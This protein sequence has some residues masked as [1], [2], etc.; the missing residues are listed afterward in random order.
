MQTNFIFQKIGRVSDPQMMLASSTT[1]SKHNSKGM[2]I[3]RTPFKKGIIWAVV[4]FVA[5]AMGTVNTAQAQATAVCELNGTQFV[6][7]GAALTALDATP[8]GSLSTIKLLANINHNAG[9]VIDGKVVTFDMNGKN[10]TVN[11]ND[12]NALW[13]QNGGQVHMAGSG[14]FD[15]KSDV[16]CVVVVGSG[17]K[18]TVTNASAD[19]IGGYV[20]DGG[21][22]TISNIAN[23]N[24]GYGVGAVS[25]GKITVETARGAMGAG[26]D[27]SGSII[28]V[29]NAIAFDSSGHGVYASAGGVINVSG[30]VTANF[31]SAIIGAKAI[32]GGQITIEGSLNV[33]GA[34]IDVDGVVKTQAQYEATTTKAGYLTYTGGTST[35]WVKGEP[36]AQPVSW[37][38]L[39]A[40]GTSGT[41]ATTALTL[42]FDRDPQG[43]TADHVDVT[44]ATKGALTGSGTTRTLAISNILVVNGGNITVALTDPDGIAI[45]PSSRDVAVFNPA[46]PAPFLTLDYTFLDCTPVGGT[47]DITVTSNTT[48]SVSSN[49]SWVTVPAGSKNGNGTF[50][51]TIA[52]NTSPTSR[53]AAVTVTGT[54]IATLIIPVTQ[55]PGVSGTIPVIT[56]PAGA[57]APG[58]VGTPYSLTLAATN[59]PTSWAVTTGS[60][61]AGLTLNNSGVISGTPT[62]ARIATFTVT[63]T[64]ASGTSAA[65]GFSIRINSTTTKTITV[66]AQ[67]NTITAGTGGSATFPATT[68][69]IANGNYGVSA[70]GANWPSDVTIGSPTVANNAF[71]ITLHVTATVSAGIYSLS[72]TIDGTTSNTFNLVVN[73]AATTPNLSVSPASLDF[74]SSAGSKS[75]TVISNV[76]NWSV[77]SNQSWATVT[78]ASGSNNGTIT[79]H[80]AANTSASQRTATI[81]VSGTGVT[82]QTVT[83]TQDAY[84]PTPPPALDLSLSSLEFDRTASSLPFDISSNVEWTITKSA[85]AT[86]LTFTPA[87]GSNNGTVTVTA[88][89]NATGAPRT[90]TITVSGSGIAPQTITVTQSI[91]RVAN[92]ELRIEHGELRAHI[93]NGILYVIGAAQ[94]STLRVYNITGALIYQGVADGSETNGLQIRAGNFARG[95]YIVTD[96]MA[97][98]KVI[99][100]P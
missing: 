29:R 41:V 6:S 87:S 49:A 84:D 88:A 58:T 75:F 17:S 86:W 69:G 45:S 89:A 90:A 33:G 74:S 27:G 18:A 15:L 73:P 81:T 78:P 67:S 93:D 77:S 47:V 82:S 16:T 7:L 38:G 5:M 76:A 57:L 94:G 10:L 13:V 50:A 34:Y 11:T 23:G 42:T 54:G 64:N 83:V 22:L 70:I 37:T 95:V 65:V 68:T 46:T 85:G 44:G 71:T 19:Y 48:W 4:L 8:N 1:G 55:D 32:T 9:I 26:A 39:T 28:N 99:A 52:A 63:A 62:S 92:E 59:S 60:L 36:P 3:L 40:N 79:V 14:K 30:D 25:G 61:P 43:L 56:T 21:E 2:N 66:G 98:V 24:S 20:E 72:I 51:V 100:K 80:V 35:V 91:I 12:P 97:S 96:G 53:E 31:S